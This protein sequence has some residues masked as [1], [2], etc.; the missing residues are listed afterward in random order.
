MTPICRSC[1]PGP[2]VTR[3]AVG[4]RF[5]CG[6]SRWGSLVDLRSELFAPSSK[7]R[8]SSSRFFSSCSS[9]ILISKLRRAEES[10]KKIKSALS[11][12]SNCTFWQ[13]SRTDKTC[14]QKRL[15]PAVKRQMVAEV[16]TTHRLS[17]RRACGL[18]GITRR[19]LRRAPGED[20]N[21][22][23]GSVCVS[24]PRSGAARAVRCSI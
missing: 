15:R 4:T 13:F 23:Y 8:V 17:Q 14:W 2:R 10:R 1:R 21:P 11:P 6:P 22:Y 19:T 12:G 18:I 9:G 24:W 7:S 16:M 5:R 3:I 20:R